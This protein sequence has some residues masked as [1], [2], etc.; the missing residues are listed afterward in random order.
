MA[1]DDTPRENEKIGPPSVA[2]LPAKAG[3]YHNGQWAA[4]PALAQS[5]GLI[6]SDPTAFLHAFRRHWLMALGIGFLLA[7]VAGP[8]AWF[9]I[10]PKYTA[11]SY[12]RVSIE[13]QS[14]AFQMDS[15]ATSR[16]RF[17]IYKNTQQQL[18]LSRF[19]LLAALRKPDAAQLPVI[20][21]ES[22]SGDPIEWLA[23]R[24]S[25][26]YPGKAELMQVSL[27]RSDPNEATV[28]VR[29]TVDAFLTE[30]VNAES[31]Q[32]RQR[33]SELDRAFGE[34]ETEIRSK[35]E[36]LKKVAE[37]L[38]TSDT[39]T[40]TLRQKLALEELTIY[41]QELTKVQFDIRRFNGELAAQKALLKGL[42]TFDIIDADV[43]SMVLSDPIARQL[44]IELGMRKIDQVYTEGA[45]V[46]NAKSHYADRY[47]QD[48]TIMQ[49]QFD[50]RR[51]EL[52]ELVRRK[53]A[54][55][56]QMEI[57]RLET[58]IA[59]MGEQ[60]QIILKEVAAKRA[61]A[62]KF[63]T[64]SV[65]IEMMRA[66]IKNLEAVLGEIA[67]ER[68]K[69]KVESRSTP[70]I[71]LLQRA[72]KPEVASNDV[73]RVML[74][75]MAMMA[76]MAVPA[77]LVILWDVRVKRINNCA[78]VSKGLHLPV[79]GSVPLI[80]SRI[81]RR[82]GSPS[83][84]YQTWHVRLTESV[85]GIAARV[86]RKAEMEHNRVIMVSSATGGEGKTTL[87]TQLALSLAR[88]GRRT[89]LVDFDLRR[90]AFDEVF[91]LP[92]EP[93]VCEALREHDPQ[94]TAVHQIATNNM[95]V[96]TAGRWDRTALASL[97]NG[98]AAAMFRKLREDY[99]FVIVDT[100]PILPVADAR[101]VSQHVDSVVLSVFRDV[102][103]AP[104]IQAACEILA[105]FGVH[106]IEAVVTGPNDNMYGEHMGY[107]SSISS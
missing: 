61:E 44:F 75:V 39:E 24:L 13:E 60:E 64:S 25:V 104:K 55:A 53:K 73:S 49:G 70:R 40:L 66:D 78:D 29:A 85:D 6:P 83:K 74:T 14:I 22:E 10:G 106:T 2:M 36:E 18:M 96:V 86:L 105:A 34:K 30:V 28:L 31:Y 81:I 11:I 98:S 5:P 32:K 8:A 107:E 67:T 47:Q 77:G 15:G 56:I 99:D 79:I 20:Q 41:R 103:E 84:R 1:H 93:G 42:E 76:A 91:G 97:S 45:V 4:A 50:A 95:A 71:T 88:A 12:L 72:E 80:P 17:D 33:L 27:T 65:D 23:S 48:L 37:Q 69:L 57:Q 58:S 82:L 35:R 26:S 52:N 100:S 62:E 54:G 21:R 38:G 43:E 51:A 16:E 19:V 101:F 7:A 92:L 63:G 59:V 46:A 9:G 87:A 94:A 102:S 89:V 68:E 90:P 3:D